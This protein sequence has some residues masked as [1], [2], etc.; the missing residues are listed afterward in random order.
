MSTSNDSVISQALRYKAG[1]GYK[2]HDS[3]GVAILTHGLK[4][5]IT[6]F[7]HPKADI[8]LPEGL[9]GIKRDS[10][11][12]KDVVGQFEFQASDVLFSE[13]VGMK[14]AMA[15]A[16]KYPTLPQTPEAY[17]KQRIKDMREMYGYLHYHVVLL[18]QIRTEGREAELLDHV[19]WRIHE[20]EAYR[21][22]VALDRASIYR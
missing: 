17:L 4:F 3:F 20:A 5:D 15:I 7:N 10:S 9:Y 21:A 16:S 13:G 19:E 6:D 14:S 8:P 2:D 18:Q 12:F 22:K 1:V 11:K